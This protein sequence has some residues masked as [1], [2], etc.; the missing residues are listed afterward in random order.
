ME[1]LLKRTIARQS[2]T[3]IAQLEVTSHA[4]SNGKAIPPKYTYEGENMNPPLQI[5]K[6]PGNSKSMVLIVDSLDFSSRLWTHWLVWNIPPSE[7]IHE[8]SVPGV[9]GLNDFWEHNYDGPCPPKGTDKY[10]FRV[11]ALDRILQLTESSGRRMLE[12]A[13][14]NHVLACGQLMGHYNWH[15]KA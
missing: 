5:G 13:M 2:E 8:N 4:F 7:R 1:Q 3:Q 12:A 15:V 6:L 9:Q 14:K 11:Y 10:F